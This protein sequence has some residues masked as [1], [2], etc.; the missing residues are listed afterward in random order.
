MVELHII[1]SG[2]W[3]QWRITS[4]CPRFETSSVS[5]SCTRVLMINQNDDLYI[6]GRFCVSV[7]HE[8]VTKFFFF[9]K[10][11]LV[12]KNV[13][14]KKIE[15]M[16]SIFLQNFFSIFFSIFFFKFFFSNFFSKFFFFKFF[17]FNFFLFI[18]KFFFEIFEM[19]EKKHF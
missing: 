2:I 4:V 19:G 10:L 1:H 8:K 18:C 16:K 17:F 14:L 3:Q 9:T 6:I 7:C 12:E 15:N 13:C 5:P 11:F